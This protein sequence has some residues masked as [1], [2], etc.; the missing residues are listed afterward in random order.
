MHL[1]EI[2]Q[3]IVDA[4]M[5]VIDNRNVNIMDRDGMII[6]SGEKNRINTYHKGADDV[7]KS[8]KI[9]EIYPEEVPEY[10][11]AKE[12][13]NLPIQVGDKTVG[14]VGVYGHPNEVRIIANLVKKAVELNLE[15]APEAFQIAGVDERGRLVFEQQILPILLD[16]PIDLA[17]QRETA[18]RR[19]GGRIDDVAFEGL[20]QRD[21]LEFLLGISRGVALHHRR[22]QMPVGALLLVAQSFGVQGVDVLDDA[23]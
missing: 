22:G 13:V 17:R 14:V 19:A 1:H 2:A 12:G 20:L 5:E 18:R 10:P 11:G 16:D 9:I 8:G 6:A 3:K 15:I 7:I 4:T 23:V 21:D